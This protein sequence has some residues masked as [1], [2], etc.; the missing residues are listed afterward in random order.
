MGDQKR[1]HRRFPKRTTGSGDGRPEMGRGII[2]AMN[3]NARSKKKMSRRRLF[4]LGT[5][6]AIG[7]LV[8]LRAKRDLTET[9]DAPTAKAA[10]MPTCLG[11]TGCVA[12]CPKAA[13]W[14]SPTGTVVDDELC[15][16]CGYC[17]AVCPV[18]G[19]KINREVSRD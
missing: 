3:R 12:V 15:I 18:K 13:I 9:P 14:S 11:C 8:L 16:R 4:R 7:G 2:E 5:A 6:T 17:L 19:L 10:T 1:N